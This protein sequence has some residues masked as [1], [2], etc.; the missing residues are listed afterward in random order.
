MLT[1]GRPLLAAASQKNVC[2]ADVYRDRIVSSVGLARRLQTPT[3][4]GCSAW[5]LGEGRSLIAQR[6]EIEDRAVEL[7]QDQSTDYQLLTSIPGIGPINAL[8]ILGRGR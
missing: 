7:L 1:P 2:L 3:P 6:N 5:S 4:P 8:T